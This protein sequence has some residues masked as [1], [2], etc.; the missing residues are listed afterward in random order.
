M[1]NG[2]NLQGLPLI[3]KALLRAPLDSES[4]HSFMFPYLISILSHAVKTFEFPDIQ[5]EEKSIT[6]IR[7]DQLNQNMP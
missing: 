5:Y 7:T 3:N 1:R 4:K 6:L 2:F